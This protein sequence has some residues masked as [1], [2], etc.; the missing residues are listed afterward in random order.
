[1]YFMCVDHWG[2]GGG[3]E[4][5]FRADRKRGAGMLGYPEC[6]ERE[7]LQGNTCMQATEVSGMCLHMRKPT[8]LAP[9]YGNHLLPGALCCAVCCLRVLLLPSKAT[10]TLMPLLMPPRRRGHER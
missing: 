7:T 8:E 1:M 10:S 5:G 4:E 3:G 6:V 2:R 9:A